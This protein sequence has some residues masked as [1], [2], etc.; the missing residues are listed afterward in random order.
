MKSASD[1]L[2]RYTSHRGTA[3]EPILMDHYNK[4]DPFQKLKRVFLALAARIDVQ[5]RFRFDAKH[6]ITS[7]G[8]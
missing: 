3:I 1:C 2:A 7:D 4:K 5:T 8:P 6:I